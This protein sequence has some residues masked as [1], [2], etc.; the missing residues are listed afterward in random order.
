M[1]DDFRGADIFIP[2]SRG[3]LGTVGTKPE[4]SPRIAKQ[5]RHWICDAAIA[6]QSSEESYAGC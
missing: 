2:K 6:S 1:D 4:G 3:C 5:Y